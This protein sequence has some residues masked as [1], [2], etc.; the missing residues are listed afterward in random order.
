VNQ[1]IQVK[2]CS[3]SW[4]SKRLSCG[5][6]SK[7]RFPWGLTKNN[8][9]VETDSGKGNKSEVDG[10]FNN[11]IFTTSQTQTQQKNIILKGKTKY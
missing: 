1:T 10:R 6:V 11:I 2:T 8:K 7:K 5:T 3:C 9:Y 4:Q